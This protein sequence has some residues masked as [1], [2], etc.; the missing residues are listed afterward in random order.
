MKKIISII[1]A[2][3]LA[4]CFVAC[5]N[6]GDSSTEPTGQSDISQTEKTEINLGMLKGPT[7]MGAVELLS[8]NEKGETANNYNFNLFSAPTDIVAKVLSGELDIAAVPSTMASVLYNKTEGGVKVLAV[9]TVGTLY[10]LENGDSIKSVGDLAG[11]TI[12]SAGQG[13][14][15]E[16]ALD[17]VLSRADI[18]DK[19]KVEWLPEHAA[20]V[21]KLVDGSADVVLLPEPNVTRALTKKPDARI[22]LDMSQAWEEAAKEQSSQ[23]KL[24]MGCVIV[25]SEFAKEHEDSV[26][27]F[28]KEY[29]ESIKYVNENI[30]EAASLCE[31]FEIVPKAEIAEAAIP[32]S[33]I[34]YIDGEEMQVA[35]GEF[36]KVLVD[37][38]NPAIIGGN[39]PGDDF[40]FG[41]R[42]ADKAA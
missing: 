38:Y 34:T 7:G 13:A 5:G 9:N 8:K 16:C 4:M 19:V 31:H 37:G 11:K 33:G 23:S 2:A 28:M 36:L 10:I 18:G 22:A 42:A 6:K 3:A 24:V 26:K 27:A 29:A 17:Y 14:T 21:A 25:N 15:P 30:K 40:Y 39:L 35:L 41:V 20:V 32:N 1:M 12:Y